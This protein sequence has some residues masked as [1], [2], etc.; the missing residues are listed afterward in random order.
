MTSPT[1]TPTDAPEIDPT[2]KRM[3]DKVKALLAKALG[4]DSFD[5]RE[6]LTRRA[7][8]LIAKHRIDMALLVEAGKAED[9]IAVEQFHL[10][11]P[12][13]KEFRATLS[14][15][16]WSLGCRVLVSDVGA[17]SFAW[18]HGFRSDVERVKL[19]TFSLLAQARADLASTPVPHG[20]KIAPFRRAFLRGYAY[21]I[22]ERLQELEERTGARAEQEHA[23]TALVLVDR[24]ARLDAY[25]AEQTAGV[26]TAKPLGKVSE[27]SGARAGYRAGDSADLGQNVRLGG[28]QAASL[29]AGS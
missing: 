3:A 16:A 26:E 23:G 17:D 18:I 1:T 19:L 21:R 7:E 20:S 25:W 13:A 9:P 8:H 5:E 4:T 28:G 10:R 29:G 15:V 12:Y 14:C 11:P 2:T 22:G 24:E 27:R 6:A